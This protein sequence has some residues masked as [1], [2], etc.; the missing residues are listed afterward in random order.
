M[1][2]RQ[3][4]DLSAQKWLQ[5]DGRSGADVLGLA[6]APAW[7]HGC[8]WLRKLRWTKTVSVLSVWK[9]DVLNVQWKGESSKEEVW[10]D[11]YGAQAA[12]LQPL[13]TCMRAQ[14]RLAATNESEVTAS[15]T[16]SKRAQVGEQPVFM[17]FHKTTPE[18][19]AG[20][21]AEGRLCTHSIH[22]I[23]WRSISRPQN[24]A[25]SVAAISRMK[26]DTARGAEE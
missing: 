16:Q 15:C 3:S 1:S 8:R 21:Q 25:H 7:R 17:C 26:S 24:H 5:C 6:L 4:F 9:R 20:A 13:Q 23:C 12:G 11:T 19:M 2:F 10:P 14:V 18:A 22:S